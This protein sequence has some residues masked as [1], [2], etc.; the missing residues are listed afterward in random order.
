MLPGSVHSAMLWHV[1]VHNMIVSM[2]HSNPNRW[3][4]LLNFLRWC[5]WCIVA[6]RLRAATSPPA[7]RPVIDADGE[8]LGKT[9]GF[10]SVTPAHMHRLLT[11]ESAEA[12][13]VPHRI[14]W[15]WY[16]GRWWVDCYIWYSEDGT[17]RGRSPPGVVLAVPNVTDHP[18]TA[19]VFTNHRIA[20]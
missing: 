5:V 3:M 15:S 20:V 19:S 18:S 16:T 17:G 6:Y 14:I 2:N 10:H 9:I 13:A 11:L 8:T 12:I 1:V 4:R 7:C